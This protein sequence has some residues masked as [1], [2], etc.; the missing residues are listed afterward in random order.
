MADVRILQWN[1]GV[2]AHIARHG[3]LPREV[4]E[5]RLGDPIRAPAY[6]G[7]IM[8]IG[9]T[10]STKMLAVIVEH[11]RDGVYTVI[12]ARP[13]SRKERRRYLEYLNQGEHA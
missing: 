4:E 3:V 5:V 8:L 13:A 2:I 1:P 10:R 11:Q 12:T 6:D 9:P 7:R